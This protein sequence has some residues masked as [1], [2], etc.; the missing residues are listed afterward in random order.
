[1]DDRSTLEQRRVVASLMEAYGSPTVVRQK[2]AERFAGRDPP[3]RL[4]IYRVYAVCEDWIG[5]GQLP[6]K[7]RT[8]QNR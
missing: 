2:F 3:S 5:S 6:R 8:A 1:M 7:C 4:T